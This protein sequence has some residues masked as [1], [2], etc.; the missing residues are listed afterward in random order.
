MTSTTT[1]I[2]TSNNNKIKIFGT[3]DNINLMGNTELQS[4]K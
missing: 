1:T 4:Q 2:N 3:K